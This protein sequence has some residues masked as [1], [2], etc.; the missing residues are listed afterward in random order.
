MHCGEDSDEEA[1]PANTRHAHIEMPTLPPK[2]SYAREE[3]E[4]QRLALQ[5]QLQ[6]EEDVRLAIARSLYEE[7][8]PLSL[9]AA[10]TAAPSSVSDKSSTPDADERDQRRR[11]GPSGPEVRYHHR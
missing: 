6:E 9:A 10:P 2:N 4:R 3:R 5:R 1:A 7:Q 8:T 11:P